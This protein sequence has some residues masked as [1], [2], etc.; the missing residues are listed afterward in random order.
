VQLG[1][2]TVTKTLHW[3]LLVARVIQLQH[4][5]TRVQGAASQARALAGVEREIRQHIQYQATK[6]SQVNAPIFV[7]ESFH[8]KSFF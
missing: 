2:L 8:K 6:S 4:H 1:K 3:I 7:L 5:H